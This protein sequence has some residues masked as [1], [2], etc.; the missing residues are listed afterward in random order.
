MLLVVSVG[1]VGTP[2][3]RM[4]GLDLGPKFDP[5]QRNPGEWGNFVSG[6]GVAAFETLP[7]C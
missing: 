1:T 5:M 2:P 3:G 6:Q 4:M 7:T